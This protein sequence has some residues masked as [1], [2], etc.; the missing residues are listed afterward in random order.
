LTLFGAGTISAP[1]TASQSELW[2]T[3]QQE[4]FNVTDSLCSD[5]VELAFVCILFLY[6]SPSPK[7][8]EIN[9]SLSFCDFNIYFLLI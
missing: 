9:P 7:I 2:E 6:I 4:T 8:I 1:L 3:I 5:D